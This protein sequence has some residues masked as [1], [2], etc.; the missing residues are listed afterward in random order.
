[1]PIAGLQTIAGL[2][3]QNGSTVVVPKLFLLYSQAF[4]ENAGVYFY[5]W[6]GEASGAW[7]VCVQCEQ[8]LQQPPALGCIDQIQ[9]LSPQSAPLIFEMAP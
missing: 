4:R 2:N 6:E 1:M 3:K 8:S 5:M 7:A 9:T